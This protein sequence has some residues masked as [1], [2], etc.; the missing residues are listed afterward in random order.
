M[1]ELNTVILNPPALVQED[2]SR[3]AYVNARIAQIGNTATLETFELAELLN[4]S[5]TNNYWKE[6]GQL[7]FDDWVKTLNID[8]S[9]RQV[10]Y[11]IA[12]DKMAAY[13]GVDT[14][15]KLKA[16]ITKLKEI[17]TLDPTLTITDSATGKE[18]SMA[19]IMRQLVKD[20][21]NKT[22]TEIKEIVKRLKGESEDPDDQL[23]WLNLPIRRDAKDVVARA[24]DLAKLLSGNTIDAVTEEVKDISDAMALERICGD[25]LSDPNNVADEMGEA[26][27][28]EDSSEDDS[29]T[30]SGFPLM[31]DDDDDDEREYEED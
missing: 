25:F 22:H 30:A 21:P 24:I 6:L 31:S 4:E 5:K 29:R 27:S 15:A 8:M 10:H 1:K 19:D 28:F 14:Q 3:P 2:M 17:F 26:G 16:K 11:L 13:L 9:P 12:V 23:T 18:E 7:S 20:A